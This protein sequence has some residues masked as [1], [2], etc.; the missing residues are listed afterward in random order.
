MSDGPHIL[1]VEDD[2]RL[3]VS[4][5]TLQRRQPDEGNNFKAVVRETRKSLSQHYLR[6]T[7]LS[8]SE[9]AFLLGP[10]EPK[11]FFRAFQSWTG[12]TPDSLRQS[13]QPAV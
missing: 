11:S 4:S 13:L 2:E 1:M 12:T 9:T 10:Q 7:Q 8:Y 3:A 5:R 6:K